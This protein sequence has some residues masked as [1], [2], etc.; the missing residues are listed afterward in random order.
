VQKLQNINP[1]DIELPNRIFRLPLSTLAQ[2]SKLK[3]EH[4]DPWTFNESKSRPNAGKYIIDLELYSSSVFVLHLKAEQG[5]SVLDRSSG[6]LYKVPQKSTPHN[7]DKIFK[8]PKK[9]T[10]NESVLSKPLQ[11]FK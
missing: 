1:E 3:P 4:L 5:K 11:K 2:K 6:S 9:S 7:F 8:R 10:P